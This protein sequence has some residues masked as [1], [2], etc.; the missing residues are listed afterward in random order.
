VPLTG[1]FHVLDSWQREI[2]DLASPSSIAEVSKS[3]G[4]ESLALTD[5]EFAQQRD[6]S[7]VPWAPK[8][9][10]DGRL[11]GQGRTGNLRGSYRLKLVSR[12]GFTIGSDARY[13]RWFH[14]GKKGQEPR[15]LSPGNRLPRAWN[16]AFEN[17]WQAHCLLKLHRS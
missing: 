1:D 15:L 16:R 11:V 12:F 17:V 8:K 13:R 14:G 3:L 6:P 5:Q 9:R 4:E 7:G 2:A 10:P